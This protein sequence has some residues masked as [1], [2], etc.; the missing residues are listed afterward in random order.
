MNFLE[1]KNISYKIN[2]QTIIDNVSLNLQKGQITTLIGPNG[3]G[4]TT[5]A[6]IALRLIK[7]TSGNLLANH[8]IRQGYMPQKI[9]IDKSIPLTVLDFIKL[10][11]N[12]FIDKIY[13]EELIE[14]LG[15]IKTLK[16]QL[17]AISG[18]QLQ[19][20]LFLQAIIS[21]PDFLVLDEPTQYMD[22]KAVA[23]FYHILND[24]RKNQNCSILLI[25][26]DLNFVMQ[27][28]DQ[29]Y[30]INHHICCSGHPEYLTNN[31]QYRE[32]FNSKITEDDRKIN[33]EIALY[34]HQH[35]H[36]HHQ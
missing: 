26:H 19:K 30:C 18:G 11:N 33:E 27:K 28:S 24:I 1:L 5:T 15:L 21:K 7:P 23:E 14:K 3:G 32:L 17:F 31:L 9:N 4:K 10:F 16:Q 22:I 20:I 13:F 6:K 8:K 25:S 2:K 34:H 36:N 35:D 12:N 29:V